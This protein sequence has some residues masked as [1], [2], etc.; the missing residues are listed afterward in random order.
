MCATIGH[1]DINIAGAE[2]PVEDRRYVCHH[3]ALR[4]CFTSLETIIMY[5]R[6]VCHH[7][8]LRHVAQTPKLVLILIGDMCAAIGH[9]DSHFDP[10]VG[11]GV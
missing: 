6:Y 3:W 4:P 5:R 1:C 9:C 2:M 11:L 10:C 7:W 8:A